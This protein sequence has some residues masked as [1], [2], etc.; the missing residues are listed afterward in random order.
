MQSRFGL[1]FLPLAFIYL[2]NQG[3]DGDDY[4]CNSDGK[5]YQIEV[6]FCPRHQ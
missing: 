5:T 2:V 6:L 1:L 3:N 4:T